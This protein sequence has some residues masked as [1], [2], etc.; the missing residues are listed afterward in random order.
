MHEQ[1]ITRLEQIREGDIFMFHSEIN[2][3][4]ENPDGSRE[5]IR[6]EGHIPKEELSNFDPLDLMKKTEDVRRVT[7]CCPTLTGALS[8][9][10][11][12]R[13]Y[14]VLDAMHTLNARDEVVPT[15]KNFIM[16]CTQLERM[17][18]SARVSCYRK[19]SMGM[20]WHPE[21]SMFGSASMA[22][23]PYVISTP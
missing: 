3:T 14:L 13:T 21:S 16:Q 17:L 8:I 10:K 15:V 19:S 6:I 12:G 11:K 7:V 23:N 5:I 9:T 1:Q 20:A 4:E 18:G 2:K 22:R